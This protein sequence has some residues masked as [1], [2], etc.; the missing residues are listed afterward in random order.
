LAPEPAVLPDGT[1][2]APAPESVM[3]E[4]FLSGTEPVDRA[5]PAAL[6]PGDTLLDLYEGLGPTPVPVPGQ[7]GADPTPSPGADSAGDALLDLYGDTA[8]FTDGAAGSGGQPGGKSGGRPDGH[9]SGLP[10]VL[11]EQ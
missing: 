3:E 10:S 2:T 7:P 1:L 11:D 9:G 8:G 6:A 5:E 4:Y